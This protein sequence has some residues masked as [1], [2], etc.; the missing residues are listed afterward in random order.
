LQ[1][2]G[3]IDSCIDLFSSGLLTVLVFPEPFHRLEIPA[4][5]A[6]NLGFR[7][8]SSLPIP[9]SKTKS[10]KGAKSDQIF[11][12]FHPY[13]FLQTLTKFK[14]L[15]QALKGSFPPILLLPQRLSEVL[16]FTQ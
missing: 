14:K 13:I 6:Q 2:G 7:F 5:K 12:L 9:H 10:V 15:E 8:L 4:G 3:V 1:L 16:A 11:F